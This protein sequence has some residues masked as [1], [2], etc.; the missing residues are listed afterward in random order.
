MDTC[1]AKSTFMD[2]LENENQGRH[3]MC[4][5]CNITHDKWSLTLLVRLYRDPKTETAIKQQINYILLNFEDGDSQRQFP[6]FC[7]FITL[8]KILPA[9]AE[10]HNGWSP[11]LLSELGYVIK[12]TFNKSKGGAMVW[13]HNLSSVFCF[14]ELVYLLLWFRT[15][16][17]RGVH[18]TWVAGHKYPEYREKTTGSGGEGIILYKASDSGDLDNSR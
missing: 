10:Y 5:R 17:F 6:K 2:D 18:S 14:W 15:Y 9:G 4:V 13:P 7:F 1:R 11:E 16:F 3:K 8:R 12:I